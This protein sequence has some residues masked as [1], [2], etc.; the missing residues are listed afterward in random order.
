MSVIYGLRNTNSNIHFE[1]KRN[2]DDVFH[3]HSV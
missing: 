2:V 1:A 3:E